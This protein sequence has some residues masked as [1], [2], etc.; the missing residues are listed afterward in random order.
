M[1]SF[2]ILNERD[3]YKDNHDVEREEFRGHRLRR[4]GGRRASLRRDINRWRAPLRQKS[5]GTSR[6]I[7]ILIMYMIA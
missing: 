7:W 3:D 5:A 2:A 1:D 6:M 4:S